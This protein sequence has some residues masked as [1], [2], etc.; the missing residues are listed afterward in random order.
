VRLKRKDPAFERLVADIAG[1]PMMS[2]A[3]G[4]RIWDHF[5][6]AKPEAALD[7]GT[8]MGASAAYMAGAMRENGQGRVVTIDTA[9]IPE[10]N[11]VAGKACDELWSR[12]GVADRIEH[13][14][15]PD[16]YYS[17]WLL[18]QV[19]A[20]TDSTGT[21]HPLYDFVYL[22]GVKLLTVDGVCTALIAQLLKPGGWLLLDDLRWTYEGEDEFAPTVELGSGPRFVLSDAE[23]RTAQ[24]REVFDHLVRR[25]PA[26]TNFRVEFDGWWGFAQRVPD[27][28]YG[29]GSIV[30]DSG[31]ARRRLF[32]R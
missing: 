7:L 4:R 2:T 13:I 30:A 29:A 9:Q 14:R 16:S 26:Y 21:C 25:N 23:R 32:G 18:E 22:D 12:C 3:Q 8:Y 5:R 24:I 31:P 20:Q 6:E 27:V 28:G 1:A 19:R 15:V 11:D 10:W 17:W